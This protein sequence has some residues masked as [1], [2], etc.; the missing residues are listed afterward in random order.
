[1]AL[2]EH[3]RL[4]WQ[5]LDQKS[6]NLLLC[7]SDMIK[8]ELRG[9]HSFIVVFVLAGKF[10]NSRYDTTKLR[11]S[12]HS[13]NDCMPWAPTVLKTAITG[14]LLKLVT[15]VVTR[16]SFFRKTYLL[17]LGRKYSRKIFFRGFLGSY[18]QPFTGKNVRPEVNFWSGKFCDGW[19]EHL[20]SKGLNGLGGKAEGSRWFLRGVSQMFEDF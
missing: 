8:N 6:S 17:H 1:M 18:N 5:V 20:Y 3:R 7:P 13:K 14:S 10:T 12:N 11:W 15:T 16:Y 9:H 19:N 4:E 2:R